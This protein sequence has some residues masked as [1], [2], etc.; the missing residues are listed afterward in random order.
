MSSRSG[1]FSENYT[2]HVTIGNSGSGRHD[3]PEDNSKERSQSNKKGNSPH[4][5]KHDNVRRAWSY[6][7]RSR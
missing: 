6:S 5:W 3:G 7:G 2:K 1:S 4:Q